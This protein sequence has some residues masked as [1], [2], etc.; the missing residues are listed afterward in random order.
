MDQRVELLAPVVAQLHDG[1]LY[2]S[3]FRGHDA[4]PSLRSHRF[5]DPRQNQR[6]G[7]LGRLAWPMSGLDRLA[8]FTAMSLKR[9]LVR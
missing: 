2:G 4:P 7:V 1:L 9:T 3:L 6:R 5:R 8:D